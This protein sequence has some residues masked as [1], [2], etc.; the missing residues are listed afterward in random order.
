M[1]NNLTLS[2]IIGASVASAVSGIKSVQ[3]SLKIIKD[4]SLSASEK[5]TQFFK[6]SAKSFGALTSGVS[7][8]GTSL[9]ALSQPA[10]Q[11]ES[12]MADV[13]KVVDFKSPDG[14]EKLQKDLLA[15]TRKLPLTA[16]EL[17]AI[18]AAGGQLGVAQE[19]LLSFTDTIAKMGTAFDM[20]AQNAGD[21]MAKLANVYQIPIKEIARLGDAINYL[22]DMSPAKASDIVETLGRVGGVAK[23]FGLTETQAASLAN[24]FIALG[25]TPEVAGTAINGMPI[26]LLSAE[27]GGARF[28]AA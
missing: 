24:A 8:V 15:L 11:L 5:T 27:K 16:E 23:Q 28:Q 21:S 13:R 17:A 18:A 6:N 25:K 12:A 3:N 19:D 7:A 1:A 10:I 22:S 9:Y 26:Q 20:S 14:F 2:L 4:Q